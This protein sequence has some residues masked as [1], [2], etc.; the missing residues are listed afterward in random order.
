MQRALLVLQ[1]HEKHRAVDVRKLTPSQTGS[2]I[3]RCMNASAHIGRVGGLAVALGI[4]AALASASAVAWADTGDSAAGHSATASAGGHAGPRATKATAKAKP[5]NSTSTVSARST[6]RPTASVTAAPRNPVNAAET[7]IS[8]VFAA[9]QGSYAANRSD[10]RVATTPTP[11]AAAQISAPANLTGLFQVAV[12]TP[13]HAVV[14][15]WIA[16]EIGRQV[17]DF[18]NAVAG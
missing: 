7:A 15:A 13:L 3:H 18:I 9:L 1:R 5:R 8:S 16:S 17:D 14:Q 11:A 2:R 4:G 6:T 12:Y 10:T